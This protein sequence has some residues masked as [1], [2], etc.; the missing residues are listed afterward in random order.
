MHC[1]C[2]FSVKKNRCQI[3]GILTELSC[4]SSTHCDICTCI[5]IVLNVSCVV[6]GHVEEAIQTAFLK[7]DDDM[8][9]GMRM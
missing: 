3:Y 4:S 5:I 6:E 1:E 8:T 7:L 2:F 9:H